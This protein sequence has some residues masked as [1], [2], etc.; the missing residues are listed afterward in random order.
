[1]GELLTFHGEAEDEVGLGTNVLHELLHRN[2][3]DG[4]GFLLLVLLLHL[5]VPRAELGELL[6][7]LRDVEDLV[8]W[9]LLGGLRGVDF[10]LGV[11]WGGVLRGRFVCHLRDFILIIGVTKTD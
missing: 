1:M 8:C 9:A 2:F 3:L 5:L 6:G 7:E 10:L 4:L 11:R